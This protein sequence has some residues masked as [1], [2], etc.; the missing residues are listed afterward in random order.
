MIFGAYL[1]NFILSTSCCEPRNPIP[2]QYMDVVR[3]TITTWDVLQ[4]SR[5]DDYSLTVQF[6]PVHRSEFRL[7]SCALGK[8]EH[9]EFG[10]EDDRHGRRV[11]EPA[12]FTELASI[13]KCARVLCACEV[14][15]DWTVTRISI[16]RQ[17]S[18]QS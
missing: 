1:D 3:R 5:I 7:D 4:E 14:Q 12:V 6:H 8:S 13:E 17:L 18:T 16:T 2:F 11:G 9:Q 10:Q 15:A